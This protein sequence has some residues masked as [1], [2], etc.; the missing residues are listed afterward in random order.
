MPSSSGAL[1]SVLL[2]RSW[3]SGHDLQRARVYRGQA[4]SLAGSLIEIRVIEPR[5][6]ARALG[7]VYSLPTQF[8]LDH[9]AIDAAL[10]RR[11]GEQYARKNRVLP[12]GSDG[13]RM[14]VASADPSNYQPL[15]DLSTFFGMPVQPVVIPFDVLESAIEHAQSQPVNGVIRSQILSLE[16]S[17][18][19]SAAD[20]L[21]QSRGSDICGDTPVLVRLIRALLW[22]A[23]DEGAREILI[24][25]AEREVAVSF[26]TG[27]RVH[28]VLSAAAS[29]KASINSCLKNL[30]GFDAARDASPGIRLFVDGRLMIAKLHAENHVRGERLTLELPGHKPEFLDVIDRCEEA[31]R[32]AAGNALPLRPSVM[33]HRCRA[34]VM[35]K[36]AFFCRHCGARVSYEA[37]MDTPAA[38]IQAH[39]IG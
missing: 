23:F 29:L 28:I 1:E 9:E 27:E 36:H 5:R 14:M 25:P 17:Q 3:I 6:L 32:E 38:A 13:V 11:I 12:L 19:E 30:A 21:Q 24:E 15:D 39:R 37:A 2:Q 33:C 10:L 20:E 4:R 35:V 18:L 34:P 16:E 22:R 31:L 26:R 8:R 7:E